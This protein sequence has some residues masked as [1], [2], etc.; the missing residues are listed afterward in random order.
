VKSLGYL[1]LLT[2][3]TSWSNIPNARTGN[4]V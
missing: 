2:S 4:D 1:R 3:L